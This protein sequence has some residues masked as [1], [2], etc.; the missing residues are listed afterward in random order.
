MADN[1]KSREEKE[2]EVASLLDAQSAVAFWVL[3]NQAD[4]FAGLRS[5]GARDSVRE[6]V[7]LLDKWEAAAAALVRP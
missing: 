3:E 5:I 7:E 1:L 2:R 6:I 4:V